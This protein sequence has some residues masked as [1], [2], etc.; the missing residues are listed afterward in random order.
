M[1]ARLTAALLLAVGV[2]GHA[3][4]LQLFASQEPLDVIIESRFNTLVRRAA[5]RP[6]VPG[7]LRYTG[8]GGERVSVAMTMTTRGRSRLEMCRFPPLSLDFR[9]SDAGDTLFAGQRKIK[10]VTHCGRGGRFMNYLHQEYGIYRAF[11]VLTGSSFRVRRLNVT[12]VDTEDKRREE[13]R[14]AFMIESDREVVARLGMER[15]DVEAIDPA[16][17]DPAHE[18][19]FS[20]FQYLVAN[21]DWSNR[22]GPSGEGCCHNGKVIRTAGT[23]E[24]WIVLPYDF[25]QAGIINTHYALPDERLGIRSVRQRLFR[26]RCRNLDRMDETFAKFNDKRVELERALLPDAVS[27]RARRSTLGYIDDFY[28]IINDP[29]ET[30]KRIS[31]KCLGG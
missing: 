15:L 28:T 21:T 29:E 10:L 1:P 12:Y 20:V 30:R 2:A 25:D 26:G 11:N 22:K 4:E 19:L 8:A 6:E 13:V 27:D 9:E 24:G 18:N 16:K 5:T 3:A 31:E 23:E 7:V 14:V 17:L